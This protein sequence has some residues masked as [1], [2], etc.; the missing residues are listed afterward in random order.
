MQKKLI[1]VAIAA[2]TAAPAFAQSNVTIYGRA[3][4]G[5]DAR[6]GSGGA[7]TTNGT[8]SEFRDGV[9]GGSRIG[10]KGAEDLGNGTKAI[11][12][13]EYGFAL[14]QPNYN[15]GT[16]APEANFATTATWLNR[17]S[18]IGLTGDWGTAVGGR[19]DGIRYNIYLAADQLVGGVGNFTS[20]TTQYDRADNAIAYISPVFGGGFT[21]TLAHSTNTGGV[22]GLAGGSSAKN[23]SDGHTAGGN[24][25]DDVLN[26]IMLKYSNGPLTLW[27]DFETTKQQ[28]IGNSTLKTW[29]AAGT[30]DFGVVKLGALYDSLKGDGCSNI[31]GATYGAAAGGL[32]C[33]AGYDRRNW[34]LS[35]KMPF[36]G[37]W[38]AKATYGEVKNK[39]VSNSDAKKFGLGLDYNLSKRTQI[40]ADYGRVSNGSAAAYGIMASPNSNSY[41]GVTGYDIGM[42]HNF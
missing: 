1:A 26:S 21:L 11:F 36:A 32:V 5:F 2:I 22:E 17:H 13:V 15:S 41:Y 40:F 18:Y 29:V 37:K 6:S 25:G 7:R 42:A 8:K 23:V 4:M 31:G 10:F 27:G 30:Y 19:L 35:A 3:D 20:M 39:K 38:N 12:E 9:Q 33:G 14:D 28:D 24:K 34:L 16:G